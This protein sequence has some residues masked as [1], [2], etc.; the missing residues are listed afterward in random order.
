MV[1]YGYGKVILFGEH[2][3]VYNLLGIAGGIDNKTVAV[4]EASNEPGLHVVDN[5]PAA[6]GYKEKK[7][8][9]F[10][11]SLEYIKKAMP[12]VDWATKGVKITLGGDLVAASGVGASA[13]S[14]AA[15]ARAVDE[16]F[17]LGLDDDAIND[18]AY[19]GEKGYHGNPSGLDNTCSTYGTLI[20]FRRDP[21]GNQISKL[22]LDEK[23]EMVM[24]NTGVAADTK[25]VVAGVRERKDREPE[26]YEQVF[27]DYE[28]VVE[29]ALGA[30]K[31]A[32]WKRVGELMD[33]NQEL[34]RAIE[35][36]HPKLE[37]LIQTAKS[38]GAYGAKITG[39]GAGG[40]MVAL[41]PGK[42]LQEKVASALKDKVDIV[43]KVSVGG[44]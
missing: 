6:P 41:T 24:A 22:E 27:E 15:I 37:E 12:Q 32:D 18:I 10:K 26:K 35:V 30:L 17:G 31:A 5:R 25:A 11:E 3:V 16:L 4:A 33:R 44:K 23:V 40:Y 36:S 2:F 29:E 14:C 38:A 34:L 1:G 20:T 9:H 7:A 8:E 19:E 13:A 42:E 43:L 21:A 28:S 39:G